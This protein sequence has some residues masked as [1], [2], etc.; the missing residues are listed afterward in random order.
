[1][2]AIVN[3]D[4]GPFLA[5]SQA[6]RELGMPQP[7]AAQLPYS[8]AQRDWVESEAMSD[9]LEASG[10]GVV[11]SF[12]LAGGVL[13]GKYET[14]ASGRHAADIED[15]ALAARRRAGR[16]LR[17]LASEVGVTPAALAIAFALRSPAVATALFGA[18]SPE[19]IAEN[20]GALRVSDE[21][22]E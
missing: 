3:W 17:T 11:A 12:V 21:V 13:T 1:A 9:A 15:S 4:P 7:C 14:G 22:A 6:A 2:W 5:A 20:V 16:E 18:T 8:F 10:A 19:Q